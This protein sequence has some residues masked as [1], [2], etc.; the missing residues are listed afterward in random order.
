MMGDGHDAV[1]QLMGYLDEGHCCTADEAATPG[2]DGEP[3][4]AVRCSCGQV[5]PEPLSEDDARWWQRGHRTAHGLAWQDQLPAHRLS[6]WE[7]A[8]LRGEHLVALSFD[9]VVAGLGE[10]A[11]SPMCSCEPA[12]SPPLVATEDEARRLADAH[13]RA[14]GGRWHM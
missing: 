5:A 11:W 6:E 12:W 1:Q 13:L 8:E 9:E 7:A 2:P 14:T 3:R 4:W 10:P